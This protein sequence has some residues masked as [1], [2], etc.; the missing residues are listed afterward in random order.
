MDGGVILHQSA[1][2]IQL[3]EK[4]TGLNKWDENLELDNRLLSYERQY[5]QANIQIQITF[6]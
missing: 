4:V 2:K 3:T 6:F 5:P 1:N